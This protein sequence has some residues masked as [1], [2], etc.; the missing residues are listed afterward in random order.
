M[1]SAQE[2]QKRWVENFRDD[3]GRGPRS[4]VP[5]WLIDIQAGS[6]AGLHSSSFTLS[7]EDGLHSPLSSLTLSDFQIHL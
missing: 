7:C 5:R 2:A 3:Q 4:P 6:A 1:L